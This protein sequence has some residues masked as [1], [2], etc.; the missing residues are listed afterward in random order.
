[1][2]I[3]LLCTN[4]MRT[5]TPLRCKMVDNLLATSTVAILH[6]IVVEM[7]IPLGLRFVRF[8]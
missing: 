6:S 4:G 3:R 5:R 1:M 2:N 8:I 7:S